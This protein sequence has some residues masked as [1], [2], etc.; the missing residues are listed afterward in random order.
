MNGE[1]S[2]EKHYAEFTY[3]FAVDGG[4]QGVHTLGHLPLGANVTEVAGQVVEAVTSLGNA[5]VIC[6][7]TDDD[8]GFVASTAKAA[9]GVNAGIGTG[10]PAAI[11]PVANSDHS[12]DVNITI[13]TAD[14]TAGKFTIVLGYYIMSF[15][16][17]TE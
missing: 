8:N 11:Q 13:G 14:L 1:G 6:G 3:D 10:I 12:R 16:E 2:R 7:T 5:T 17:I 15:T 4:A 9:L